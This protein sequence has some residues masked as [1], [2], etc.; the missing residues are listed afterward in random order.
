MTVASRR[1]EAAHHRWLRRSLHISW[2]D[3]ATNKDVRKMTTEET[4]ETIIRM[5]RLRWMGH[6]FRMDEGRRRRQV[7]AWN[8]EGKRK[9]GRPRKNWPETIREDLRCLELTWEEAEEVG[10]DRD[11]W[12]RCIARCA[13]MHGKD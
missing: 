6:F 12:R 3:K 2:R 11:E 13:T 5:R 9:R 4:L 7:M 1:L 10:T 8:G